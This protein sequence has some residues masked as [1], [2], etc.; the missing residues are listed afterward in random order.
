MD[1]IL[2]LIIIIVVLYGY[3]P[4]ELT[5]FI[6]FVRKFLNNKNSEE[7]IWLTKSWK[8]FNRISKLLETFIVFP[9][10]MVGLWG[11]IFTLDDG[12]TSFFFILNVILF[13]LTVLMECIRFI[14]SIRWWFKKRGYYK[15]NS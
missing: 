13:I 8:S 6:I 11:S 10:A 3:F 2:Y 1:D 12:S 7:K 14:F 9:W 5:I 15:D 4:I